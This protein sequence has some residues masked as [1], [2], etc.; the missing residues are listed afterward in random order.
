M[1]LVIQKPLMYIE[2]VSR[3]RGGDVTF[4]ILYAYTCKQETCRRH[5]DY[6][7]HLNVI[8]LKRKREREG[9]ERRERE[10]RGATKTKYR[11]ATVMVKY[12]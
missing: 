8:W 4:V 9:R 5:R 11:Y 12:F 10:E 3:E 6:V 1:R 7:C 2:S